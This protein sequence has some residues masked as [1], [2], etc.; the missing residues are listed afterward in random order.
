MKKRKDWMAR[1]FAGRGKPDTNNLSWD[2]VDSEREI[3][4]G[5]GLGVATFPSGRFG[6]EAPTPV[7][8]CR[9]GSIE[10]VAR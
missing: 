10:E 8:E 1:G 5:I 9:D 2:V 6:N 7:C 4:T 3:S